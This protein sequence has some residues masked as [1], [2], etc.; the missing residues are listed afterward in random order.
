MKMLRSPS[1]SSASAMPQ[2]MTTLSV[3]M[4]PFMVVGMGMLIGT[5]LPKNTLFKNRKPRCPSRTGKHFQIL[6]MY[7]Y[8]NFHAMLLFDKHYYYNCILTLL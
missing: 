4:S 2:T 5:Q 7:R 3:V 1:V 6:I 8:G